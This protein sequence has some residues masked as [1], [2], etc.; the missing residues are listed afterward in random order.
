MKYVFLTNLEILKWIAKCRYQATTYQLKFLIANKTDPEVG[1]KG[2]PVQWG[3]IL[4]SIASLSSGNPHCALLLATVAILGCT[5]FHCAALSYYLSFQS[6]AQLHSFFLENI[7][8][9]YVVV[10]S[11]AEVCDPTI[12]QTRTIRGRAQNINLTMLICQFFH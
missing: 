7:Q 2:W 6:K 12:C 4:G 10:A 3:A 5:H 11:L 8:W 1:K 9:S